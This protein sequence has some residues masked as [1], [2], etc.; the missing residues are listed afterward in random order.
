[1]HYGYVGTPPRGTLAVKFNHNSKEGALSLSLS[2]SLTHSLTHSLIHTLAHSST[3]PRSSLFALSL[4]LSLFLFYPLL[5]TFLTLL[6]L[7]TDTL[8]FLIP[9]YTSPA[10][11]TPF[12]ATVLGRSRSLGIKF[13]ETATETT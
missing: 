5:A 10:V 13:S 4:S 1:M 8:S 3:L 7:P 6:A 9:L 2:L 11:L 12:F